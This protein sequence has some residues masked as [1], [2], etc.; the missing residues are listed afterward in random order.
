MYLYCGS[1]AS[2]GAGYNHL[3][4]ATKQQVMS[5]QP[6]SI[7]IS[8]TKFSRINFMY[9][10]VFLLYFICI[11][12]SGS[13]TANYI[14]LFLHYMNKKFSTTKLSSINLHVCCVFCCICTVF[15]LYVYCICISLY[16]QATKRQLM[17]F[18]RHSI[19]IKVSTTKFSR[20]NFTFLLC[21]SLFV[22]YFCCIC[23]SIVFVFHCIVRQPNG[24]LCLAAASL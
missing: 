16:C 4:Q 12:L 22:L 21:I 13:Q 3:C 24:N 19:N 2:L 17:S 18:C 23:I 15:L 11:V 14:P 8:T 7:R 10:I 9:F 5:R 20:I 6:I 1:V